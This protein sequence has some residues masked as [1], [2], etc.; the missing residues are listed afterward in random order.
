MQAA[1]HPPDVNLLRKTAARR[2]SPCPTWPMLSYAYLPWQCLY[3]QR[4]W[5][6]KVL[7]ISC[8]PGMCAVNFS[9]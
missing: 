1:A 6:C 4:K 9:S 8:S 3:W 5:N 7:S 2:A